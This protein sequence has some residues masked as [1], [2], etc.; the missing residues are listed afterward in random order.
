[1]EFISITTAVHFGGSNPPAVYTH[2]LYI[3]NIHRPHARMSH[4]PTKSTAYFFSVCIA[5]NSRISALLKVYALLRF[6]RVFPESTCME[7][8]ISKR[9][10]GQPEYHT[11]IRA[12]NSLCVLP[13]AA[14]IL[15]TSTAPDCLHQRI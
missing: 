7:I 13:V 1:M 5:I 2:S 11:S 6:I 3:H 15:Q 10:R 8:L 14:K 9:F 12:D 4:P